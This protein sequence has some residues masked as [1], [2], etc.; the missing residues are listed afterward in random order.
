VQ[1]RMV[2]RVIL[3]FIVTIGLGVESA[4]AQTSRPLEIGAQITS[5]H[6]GEL[7]STD[8]GLGG[9][10]AWHPSRLIGVEGELNF[11]PSDLPDQTPVSRGRVEGLF[12]ITA[13]PRF[14]QW[15]PFARIRPGFLQVQSSPEP[16]ACILIF[17]APVSCGLAAGQTLF[18][19]DVGGGVEL[20]TPGRTFVRL[21]VG[22]RMIRYQG[23]AIDH[24]RNVHDNDFVGH[25]LRFAIGA[26]WRF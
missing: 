16:L 21:D 15:R 18:A 24:D 1:R 2:A 22:D 7:D 23:P 25:D 10:A 4:R 12:G 17:P 9:R 6:F 26:G 11:Y 20:M 19:L 3:V 8:V 5:A 14:S 13:G